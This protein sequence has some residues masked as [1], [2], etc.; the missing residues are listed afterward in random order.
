MTVA[1]PLVTEHNLTVCVFPAAYCFFKMLLFLLCVY[2]C[3]HVRACVC[4]YACA[5]AR[6][7]SQR[8]AL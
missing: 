4:M 1:D 6:V 2:V 5:C 7:Y 3:V 8:A